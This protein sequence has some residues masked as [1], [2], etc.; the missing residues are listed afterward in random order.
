MIKRFDIHADYN[1]QT[2]TDVHIVEHSDGA[3]VNYNDYNTLLQRFKNVIDYM[4]GMNMVLKLDLLE[5][6]IKYEKEF[7]K[8]IEE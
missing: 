5:R 6:K 1:A 2:E 4:D 3:Y 7:I 8:E